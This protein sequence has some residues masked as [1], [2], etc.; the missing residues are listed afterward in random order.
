MVTWSHFAQPPLAGFFGKYALWAVLIDEVQSASTVGESVALSG[1]MVVSVLTS[2]FSMYYYLR[3][4]KVSVFDRT[5]AMT[6]L[7]SISGLTLSVSAV[8]TGVVLT[9]WA[10]V[11]PLLADLSAV[12][13][14][15]NGVLVNGLA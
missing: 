12:E 10:A 2:L 8:A 9:V 14:I 6:A 13:L 15:M 5:E 1:L 7:P 11:L 4:L 3:V